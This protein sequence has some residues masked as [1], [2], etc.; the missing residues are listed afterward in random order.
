MHFHCQQYVIDI[1]E[2]SA[3]L[4]RFRITSKSIPVISLKYN[5]NIIIRSGSP[6]L[7][8]IQTL[9]FNRY[10]EVSAT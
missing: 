9:L 6:Y 2:C 5:N 3:V 8:I 1:S 10:Y 4:E 7:F